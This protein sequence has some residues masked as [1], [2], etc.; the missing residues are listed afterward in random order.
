MMAAEALVAD[1]RREEAKRLAGLYSGLEIGMHLW[2][3]EDVDGKRYFTGYAGPPNHRSLISGKMS[4]DGVVV[5]SSSLGP[6]NSEIEI[7]TGL[8]RAR[9]EEEISLYACGKPV[10][11]TLVPP[12]SVYDM[13]V[14]SHHLAAISELEAILEKP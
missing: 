5:C 6:Q 14:I 8:N 13:E 1:E 12:D 11:I 3:W 2:F 4:E 10:T 9:R 7:M